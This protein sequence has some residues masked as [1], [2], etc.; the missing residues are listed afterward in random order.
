[1]D[2]DVG[3]SSVAELQAALTN[4]AI[5]A[6]ELLDE[7]LARIAARDSRLNSVLRLDPAAREQAE[8]SDRHRRGGNPRPL[9]GIPVLVKD[10]VAVTGLPTTA[11]SRALA[12]SRP[13]DAELVTRLR[14]AGATVVGKANLSEWANFRS[15]HSTSGW[16]A[17]G[18][19]TRNPHVLDRD[20]SGS[21]S[22]SA[23]A[24]AAGFVPLAIGT[25]TDG[26]ILS[27]AGAC[28][29]VGFKPEL[30]TVPGAGIVPISSAQDTAGPMA[31]HVA[32]A[33]LLYAVL[34]GTAS[35]GPRTDALRGARV[36]IWVAPGGDPAADVFATAVR[37]IED[38][39]AVTV[40]VTLGTAAMEEDEWPALVAEFRH[41]IDAYLSAAPG[42]GVRSLAELVEFNRADGLE[43]VHF[44]QELF[45]QALDAAPLTDPGYREHRVRAT[46]AARA[47]I[48][49]ALAG[50]GLDAIVTL[51]NTPAGPIDYAV[52]DM[53]GASTSGPAA[54][55]GY[56][57]IT[58]PAGFVGPLPIGIS[59]LGGPGST[60]RLLDLAFAFEQA[61][62]AHRAPGWLP[63]L[64]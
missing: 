4:R 43:L 25:E 57:S 5:S 34:S 63:T 23:A 26:S 30:G 18:G 56:P 13:P 58:V 21:S 20:P 38:A 19:Q 39:G 33:A 9:E 29:V 1:M 60:A 52:G 35:A 50:H 16:S 3:E 11:G 8:A 15:T 47:A 22:G 6:A 53:V 7:C 41:E 64:P 17:L 10:N 44:G 24:V 37:V 48:D 42:A 54:V 27:P 49:T 14:A 12:E 46:G 62:R 45:E 28:G 2:L 32:D 36:G 55:A 61:T 40:P 59:L 31:R 51:T